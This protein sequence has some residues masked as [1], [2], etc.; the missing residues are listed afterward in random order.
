MSFLSPESIQLNVSR[1]RERK[2]TRVGEMEEKNSIL[3]IWVWGRVLL[4]ET[5]IIK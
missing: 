1:G 3:L 5:M 2:R 4:L